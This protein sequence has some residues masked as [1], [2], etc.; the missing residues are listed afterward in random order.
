MNKLLPTFL[1]LF[2]FASNFLIA[3]ITFKA[4]YYL[5]N[6][7]NRID[8]LI[9]D[10]DWKSNPSSFE[11]KLS[12]SSEVQIGQVQ[13]VKLFQINDFSKFVRKDVQIDRWDVLSEATTQKHPIY[14]S[15][16]LFLREVIAGPAT[17]YAYVKNSFTT[18]FY[19]VS[20]SQTKQL[21]R[22]EYIV[23]TESG[24]KKRYINNMYKR[25]LLEDLKSDGISEK[26]AN[27]L[28]Y[29]ES[30]F[31]KFFQ[32]YN[33]SVGANVE[34]APPPKVKF[35]FT[36]KVGVVQNALKMTYDFD[37]RYN[38]D[39][40]SKTQVRVGLD[41]ELVLPFNRN[42]WGI[43]LEPV[44]TAYKADG[45][46]TI[47]S[48]NVDYKAVEFQ[49]GLRH[50]MF[51]NEESKIFLNVGAIY[52]FSIN[53]AEY[54][55]QRYSQAFKYF[56]PAQALVGAGYQYNKFSVEVRYLGTQNIVGKQ[57]D[58]NGKFTSLAFVLG[59]EIF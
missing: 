43:F 21:I 17:L 56:V 41:M 46:G 35:H 22:K 53:G 39:F 1:L 29:Y 3:Q 30:D 2:V 16:T 50:Y 18:F 45:D 31:L 6:S 34:S 13:D 14:N 51:L 27:N 49:F 26:Q 8:C 15:E 59:Y 33:T 19:Q 24:Y 9:K 52:A 38:Y 20:D 58:W 44:Y 11:Y 12:E 25:Q 4:G 5:D 55:P 28:R 10:V 47:F 40:G 32:K 48:D 36:P 42:K 54:H 37:D 23:E 7:D 57:T